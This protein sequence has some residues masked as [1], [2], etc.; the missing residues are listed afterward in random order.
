MKVD[1]CQ[2]CIYCRRNAYIEN[3][4]AKRMPHNLKFEN[5]YKIFHKKSNPNESLSMEC[6]LLMAPSSESGQFSKR[7]KPS[8]CF[9]PSFERTQWSTQKEHIRQKLCH[10][11]KKTSSQGSNREQFPKGL[12]VAGGKNSTTKIGFSHE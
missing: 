7:M 4:K 8:E 5:S 9:E 2:K 10:Q 12:F 3:K 1:L 11:F 6:S